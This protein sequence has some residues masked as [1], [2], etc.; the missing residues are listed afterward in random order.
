MLGR[1]R[2]ILA[3]E[4]SRS[5]DWSAL[6]WM[7]YPPARSG[8]EVNPATAMR[9]P[10]TLACVRAI[11]E[12]I[13]ALPCRLHQIA[14][15]RSFVDFDEPRDRLLSAWANPW[16]SAAEFRAI[17]AMDAL[18]HGHAFAPV[19]RVNGEPVELHRLEPL[20]VA[21]DVE[22]S[23]GAPFY[24]LSLEDGIYDRVNWW[25]VL[26]V[27]VPGS[28]YERSLN[29]IDLARE[30]IGLE[31]AL[32]QH[33]ARL[34]GRGGRPGGLLKLKEKH[35][36][37]SI[38]A[39]KRHWDAV[40]GGDG[41]GGIAVLQGGDEYQQVMLSLVDSQFHELRRFAV[42]EICRVFRVPPVIAGDMS[43]AVWRNVE[44]LG[45]QYLTNCIEPWLTEFEA[46]FSRVLIDPEE[47]EVRTVKFETAD[48]TKA[49]TVARANANRTASGGAWL[50]PNEI[51]ERE[52]LPPIQGGDELIRQAGQASAMPE[53]EEGDDA[54][55]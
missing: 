40:H 30:A 45:R 26:H 22:P 36:P 50:T 27:T 12:T 48:L 33:E 18:L 34:M 39:L 9:S 5:L 14:A 54:D 49:D 7:T 28:T 46:A 1:L 8:V 6:Q 29:L 25:N 16:T 37:E 35:S 15:G 41:Q 55:R 31:L 13:A 20:R 47:R 11:S 3:P 52:G 44:S 4:E 2:K 17:M 21:P 32:Q 24:R 43:R 23:T 51:R 42:E 38:Q 19:V 10:T 53:E